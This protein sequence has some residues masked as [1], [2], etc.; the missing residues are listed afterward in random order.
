M[1][2]RN[3]KEA[4]TAAALSGHLFELYKLLDQVKDFSDI[5]R[6]LQRNVDSITTEMWKLIRNWSLPGNLAMILMR[7]SSIAGAL[8]TIGNFR[9]IFKLDP[10]VQP[11]DESKF[12]PIPPSEYRQRFQYKF[13]QLN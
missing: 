8:N 10:I 3:N 13:T 6:P 4:R 2:Q 11:N 9:R 12:K 7:E 1:S 5:P